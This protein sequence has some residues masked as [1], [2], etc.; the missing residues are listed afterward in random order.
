MRP[1]PAGYASRLLTSVAGPAPG[2]SDSCGRPHRAIIINQCIYCVVA[3][4]L[5]RISAVW[6]VPCIPRRCTLEA[7]CAVKLRGGSRRGPLKP[8]RC[9]CPGNVPLKDSKPLAYRDVSRSRKWYQGAKARG[10]DGGVGAMY[11]CG[12]K[13]GLGWLIS[14][15]QPPPPP[16]G[17]LGGC[18]LRVTRCFANGAPS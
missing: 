12:R 9:P 15:A 10:E 1:R 4:A 6:R 16:P 7:A 18:S 3:C 17:A 14:L 8:E 2:A 5:Y 11:A 13:R